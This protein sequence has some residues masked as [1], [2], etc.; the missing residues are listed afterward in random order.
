MGT[1]PDDDTKL[2]NH[3]CPLRVTPE[4]TETGYLYLRLVEFRV[5]PLRQP[6]RQA[7]VSKLGG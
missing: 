2:L 5:R 4:L 7:T 3:P 6:R 1:Q